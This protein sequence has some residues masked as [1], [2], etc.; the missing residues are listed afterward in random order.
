MQQEESG[1]PRRGTVWAC[2][3]GV[4]E[5]KLGEN[6]GVNVYFLF[7]LGPSAY[8]KFPNDFMGI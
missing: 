7:L 3:V 4:K 2:G 6:L 5:Q 1:T 8:L